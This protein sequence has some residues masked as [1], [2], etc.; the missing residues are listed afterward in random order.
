M[1][2]LSVAAAPAALGC[3]AEGADEH[4]DPSAAEAT[5]A[6]IQEECRAATPSAIAT[7]ALSADPTG[8]PPAEVQALRDSI[9]AQRRIGRS[10]ADVE[11]PG[12]LSDL[13]ALW[14]ERLDSSVALLDAI[15]AGAV[16]DP[17]LVDAINELDTEIASRAAALGLDACAVAI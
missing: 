14:Q 4:A 8:S 1:L 16:A 5:A 13:A 11:E 7:T 9:V 3:S 15:E 17:D 10:F 6:E 2:V 12:P